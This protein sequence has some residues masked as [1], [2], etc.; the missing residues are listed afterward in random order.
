MNKLLDTNFNSDI[1]LFLPTI[2]L[3]CFLVFIGLFI[4][5]A[6]KNKWTIRKANQYALL[7]FIILSTFSFAKAA[8]DALLQKK[9]I[10]I[11]IKKTWWG[12]PYGISISA[13]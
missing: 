10:N 12:L 1:S 9:G 8:I 13:K 3:I 2:I 5:N 4:F 11:S 7:S 6:S